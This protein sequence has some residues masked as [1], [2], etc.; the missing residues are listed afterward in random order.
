[1][2]A[3]ITHYEAQYGELMLSKN[4]LL[5]QGTNGKIY[6]MQI[7]YTSD[8]SGEWIPVIYNSFKIID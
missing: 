3:L 4:L 8:L 6:R 7:M 5:I 2:A 1:M